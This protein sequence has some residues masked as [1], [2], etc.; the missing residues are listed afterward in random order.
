MR[1]A[2]APMP[3]AAPALARWVSH[4]RERPVVQAS[5]ALNIP[6]VDV[7]YAAVHAIGLHEKCCDHFELLPICELTRREA[8]RCQ[9]RANL[10]A[11]FAHQVRLVVVD[12][13]R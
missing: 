5:I 1:L 7:C 12:S 6:G 3:E 11:G 4:H 8:L 2:S 9:C 13:V 10:V